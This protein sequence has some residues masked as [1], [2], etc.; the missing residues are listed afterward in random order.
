MRIRRNGAPKLTV[1][2]LLTLCEDLPELHRQLQNPTFAAVVLPMFQ[3]IVDEMHAKQGEGSGPLTEKQGW[4]MLIRDLDKI[5]PD[6]PD[7]IPALKKVAE[8]EAARA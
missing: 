5:F 7:L 4:Q 1:E 6:Y 8:E 2:F 3:E